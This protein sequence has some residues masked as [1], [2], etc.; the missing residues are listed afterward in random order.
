MN[1]SKIKFFSNIEWK[2]T[3]IIFIILLEVRFLFFKNKK[4]I[5]I[6][7][8]TM[9]KQ[10][11]LY[12]SEFIQYYIK[13]GI[14]HIF[15]YD[16]NDPGT[17]KFS[18]ITDKKYKKYVTIKE[19]KTDKIVNQ[20]VAFSDCYKKNINKFDWFLMVDM[21]EFLFIV[22]NTLK[23]YL[24]DKIFDKCDFIKFHWVI[25]S[26]NG[27]IYY[28]SRSLFERF[29]PPYVKSIFIKSIIRGNISDLK[30][31]VHSPFISPLRNVTCNNEG[32]IIYYKYMNFESIRHI[33]INKAYIIHFKYKSTEEFV[34]KIKRGYSNWHNDKLKKVFQE[35]INFYLN[36]NNATF[37][38]INYIETKLNINL[39]NYY[40]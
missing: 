24:V 28:D 34:N 38:K 25:P 40:K 29:K 21:D 7:L 20:S 2:K 33:N 22:N 36:H 39:S 26:D 27:N 6:A 12:I 9:G 30:Y 11:N 4:E 1:N 5:K 15:L 17:E 32:K 16:D 37:E 10:E 23:S 13:L 19:A 14:D 35:N 8:C 31:W 18:D 3:L